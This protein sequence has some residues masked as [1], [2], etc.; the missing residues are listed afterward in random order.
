MAPNNDSKPIL[1]DD[2]FRAIKYRMIRGEMLLTKAK[3]HFQ[4]NE[5]QEEQLRFLEEFNEILN[6]EEKWH[7]IIK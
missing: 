5:E 7:T 6:N 2:Q 3:E 1:T 4:M